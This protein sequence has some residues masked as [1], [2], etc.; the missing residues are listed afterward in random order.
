M[1]IQFQMA[2]M[3]LVF[4]IAATPIALA[5]QGSGNSDMANMPG[6]S[7][8]APKPQTHDMPGMDMQTMMTQCADMRRR[9]KPG[10]KMTPDMQKMMSQCDE[11]DKSMSA[12]AQPYTPPADRRR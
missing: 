7:K 4:M 10:A 9:M 6:M 8:S 3:A 5:Q 11:M 1:N 2:G 12:P